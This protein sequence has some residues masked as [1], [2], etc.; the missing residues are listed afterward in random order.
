MKTMPSNFDPLRAAEAEARGWLKRARERLVDWGWKYVTLS[1]AKVVLPGVGAVALAIVALPAFAAAACC[2]VIALLV[3]YAVYATRLLKRADAELRWAWIAN[4]RLHQRNL[5]QQIA[6]DRVTLEL[7]GERGDQRDGKPY[8]AVPQDLRSALAHVRG[9]LAEARRASHPQPPGAA[10]RA[11]GVPG[12]PAIAP[13]KARLAAREAEHVALKAQIESLATPSDIEQAMKAEDAERTKR[14]RQ[15]AATA[16][17]R[18]A[19][20]RVRRGMSATTP[21]PGQTI[22]LGIK[23]NGERDVRTG[24]GRPTP[25]QIARGED[26]GGDD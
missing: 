21:E 3:I 11:P 6:T 12:G 8:R 24:R 5:D 20:D 23:P 19:R 14:E 10:V 13:I 9:R 15:D 26:A 7:M 4:K 1:L 2:V 16:A 22:R 25:E 17:D 18:D